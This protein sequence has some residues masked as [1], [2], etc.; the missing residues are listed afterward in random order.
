MHNMQD[1]IR[2]KDF[3]DL[4]DEEG[5]IKLLNLNSRPNPTESLRHLCRKHGLPYIP[6]GRGLR[7]F[8]RVDV[9]NFIQSKLVGGK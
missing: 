5:V 9:D 4:L 7:R 2:G 1:L 3:D 6:L 8:R